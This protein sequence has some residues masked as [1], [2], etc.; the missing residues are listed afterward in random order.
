MESF[1]TLLKTVGKIIEWLPAVL[2]V[3]KPFRP[4]ISQFQINYKQKRATLYYRIEVN[5]GG[6]RHTIGKINIPRLP[7]YKISN[8]FGEGFSNLNHLIKISEKDNSYIIKTNQLPPC[9]FFQITL[10]GTITHNALDNVIRIQKAI[11]KDNTSTFDK[12]WLNAMINDMDTLEKIY[13]SLEVNEVN[14]T[15]KVNVENHFTTELPKSLMRGVNAM[16]D[17]LSAGRGSDRQKL[18]QKWLKYRYSLKLDKDELTNYFENLM[19][20]FDL[21]NY[22][23]IEEPFYFGSLGGTSA[24]KIIPSS[25]SVDA[26]TD[27]SFNKPAAKG[28]LKFHKVNFKKDLRN[29]LK[30]RWD[31][32][33]E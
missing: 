8:F 10:D 1:E 18:F 7:N 21:Y 29:E 5:E 31:S 26:I 11:N 32:D 27:L 17:F 16:N 14:C 19:N 2:K 25:F 33:T 13:K 12:Y 23:E 28:Y 3:L 9:R 24:N 30:D 20:Q 6:V 22:I 4:E 15:V